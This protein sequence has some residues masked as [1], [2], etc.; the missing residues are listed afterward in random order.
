[1]NFDL[2][3]T[4]VGFNALSTRL[5]YKM[6]Y[7][8]LLNDKNR[9]SGTNHFFIGFETL[10]HCT[11]NTACSLFFFFSKMYFGGRWDRERG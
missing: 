9:P 4:E 10:T 6:K 8:G 1:M 3:V 2:L 5:G 7:T 11:L